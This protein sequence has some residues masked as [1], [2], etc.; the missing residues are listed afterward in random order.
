MVKFLSPAALD[1]AQFTVYKP[2]TICIDADRVA[3]FKGDGD[4]V[5]GQAFAAGFKEVRVLLIGITA[6]QRSKV[7]DL[8]R[9]CLLYTS[10]CV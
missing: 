6:E 7:A 8:P 9:I 1:I 10:R 2:I 3:V 4:A 5:G